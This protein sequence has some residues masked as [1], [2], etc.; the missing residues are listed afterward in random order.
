MA[1]DLYYR[2]VEVADHDQIKR[3][4]ERLFPVKSSDDFYIDIC[5]KK[6]VH[7]ERLFATLVV[8]RSSEEVVGFIFAEFTGKE[9]YLPTY[10]PSAA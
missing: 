2:D 7:G 8:E 4:H 5:G 1:V 9:T 10:L 6:G 3:L